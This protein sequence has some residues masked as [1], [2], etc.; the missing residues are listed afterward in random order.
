MLCIAQTIA[1]AAVTTGLLYSGLLQENAAF[2]G[3]PLAASAALTV[4]GLGLIKMVREGRQ[5]QS[6]A[7]FTGPKQA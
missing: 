2:D 6:S 7:T 5:S 4:V 1:F 3:N